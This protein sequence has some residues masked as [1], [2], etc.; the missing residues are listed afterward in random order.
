MK[1]CNGNAASFPLSQLVNSP[2]TQIR[3]KKTNKQKIRP[4][5]MSQRALR[6]QL[7]DLNMQQLWRHYKKKKKKKSDGSHDTC[8]IIIFILF[9]EQQLK[10]KLVCHCDA[11]SIIMQELK[12]CASFQIPSGRV[13]YIL[14]DLLTDELF[15]FWGHKPM[16]ST[17]TRWPCIPAS[18][19]Q[20]I[21][22]FSFSLLLFCCFISL[23]INML[24]FSVLHACVTRSLHIV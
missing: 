11:E 16:S 6:S 15:T 23:Y 5:M 8:S 7:S 9:W 17:H 12:R 10:I 1:I 20:N 19:L 24:F 4:H 22:A 13:H 3:N 14:V 2:S 21:D 18:V